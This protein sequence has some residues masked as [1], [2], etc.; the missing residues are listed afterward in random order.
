[1]STSHGCVFKGKSAISRML[2]PRRYNLLKFPGAVLHG[3]VK[4]IGSVYPTRGIVYV[5][6]T[7]R[8]FWKY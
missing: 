6:V 5:I 2:P 1:M 4:M 7:R 3:I 8:R